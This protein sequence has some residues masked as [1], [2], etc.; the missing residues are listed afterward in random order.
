MQPPKARISPWIYIPSLLDIAFTGAWFVGLLNGISNGYGFLWAAI[1]I[2]SFILTAISLIKQFPIVRLHRRIYKLEILLGATIILLPSIAFV[3]ADVRGAVT[4]HNQLDSTP[5]AIGVFLLVSCIAAMAILN[6]GNALL[7]LSR[8]RH[9]VKVIG[10]VLYGIVWLGV[11]A[12]SYFIY[13][14]EY[15]LH[16]PS[17]E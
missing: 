4:F 1:G 17:T 16:D 7:I 15:S 13:S 11:I 8:S 3:I 5:S 6:L 10:A 12:A 9:V 14:I 2:T